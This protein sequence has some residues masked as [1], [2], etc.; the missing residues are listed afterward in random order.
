M[1]TGILRVFVAEMLG[2]SDNSNARK[3]QEEGKTNAALSD[4]YTDVFSS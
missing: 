4:A 1:N 3:R 2:L